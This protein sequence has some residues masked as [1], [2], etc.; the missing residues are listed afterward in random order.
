[1]V[2]NDDDLRDP[3]VVM[4]SSSSSLDMLDASVESSS[5]NVSLNRSGTVRISHDIVTSQYIFGSLSVM[6]DHV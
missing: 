4:N 6:K 5:L 3:D 1:M 2:L